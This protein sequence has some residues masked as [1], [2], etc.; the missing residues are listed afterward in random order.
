MIVVDTDVI[1][2]PLRTHP[3]ES[4]VSWLDAQI[5]ET[6]YLTT[7]TLAELRLGIAVL[8]RGRR[9]DRLAL[10]V[11]DDLLPAFIGRILAFDDRPARRTRGCAR[12]H[13]RRV[14]RSAWPTATLRRSPR[15][16]FAVATR[17]TTPFTAA[18]LRVINPF[19]EDREGG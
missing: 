5:I 16:S 7:V 15:T 6:L 14:N 8:P 17:D 9:R 18:G 3:K 13:G 1:S 10:Q 11:E 19:K 4:V 12:G 2:E